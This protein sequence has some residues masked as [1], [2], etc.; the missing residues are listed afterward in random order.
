MNMLSLYDYLGHAAGGELGKEVAAA[1]AK[2]NVKFEIREVS[3]P[4]YTGKIM[5]YP[6]NFLKEFFAAK[7]S[8]IVLTSYEDDELP[9]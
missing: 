4:K 1:A 6:E 8:P 9:F 2:S 3:N 7:Q 5:L